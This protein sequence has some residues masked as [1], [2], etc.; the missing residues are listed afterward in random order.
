MHP[1]TLSAVVLAI[2]S[3]FVLY[4]LGYDTRQLEAEVAAKERRAERAHSDIAVYK[5]ERAHLARPER[6]EA[7]ARSQG[8]AR[9]PKRNSS[10][11]RRPRQTRERRGRM[12]AM[13]R[14]MAAGR[15]RARVET[16]RAHRLR[17][18][19]VILCVGCA[20]ASI[21]VQLAR[22]AAQGSA[23][24]VVVSLNSRSP[25]PSPAPISSIARAASSRRMWSC[26]RSMPTP[27]SCKAATTSPTRFPTCSPISG[28]RRPPPHLR[29]VPPLRSGCAASLA[30]ARP[31]RARSGPPGLAFRMN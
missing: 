5:A 26:P 24:G 21:G 2:A 7:L 29:Q 20:F 17:A 12:Q 13:T 25:A 16:A 22:L 18:S 11:P 4:G 19:A 1:L 9:P 6:I 31:C 15:P 27:R 3:A 8:S 28:R 30:E 14:P 23:G 10:T